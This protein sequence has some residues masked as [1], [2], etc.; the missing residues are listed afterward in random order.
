MANTRINQIAKEAKVSNK[1]VIA[2]LAELGIE[3]ADENVEIDEDDAQLV[4]DLLREENGETISI[5][6]PLTVQNLAD[7]IGK[8]VSEVIMELMKMGT[9]ATINQEIDS[10]V[11]VQIFDDI[12]QQLDEYENEN[13]E[14]KNEL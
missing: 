2:K 9:M 6:G 12:M 10:N 14:D 8:S 1:E 3:V 4:L 5:D 11:M 7:A 13:L